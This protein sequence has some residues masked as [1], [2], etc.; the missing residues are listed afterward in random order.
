MLIKFTPTRDFLDFASI[1]SWEAMK[2][3]EE[4]H[5]HVSRYFL[6]EDLRY[7]VVCTSVLQAWLTSSN[8]LWILQIPTKKSHGVKSRERDGYCILVIDRL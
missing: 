8:R 4:N 5:T 1:T 7:S 2:K 6:C 3:S